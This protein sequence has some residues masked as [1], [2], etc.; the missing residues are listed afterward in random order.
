M[1]TITTT[2][3]TTT[4]TTTTTTLPHVLFIDDLQSVILFIA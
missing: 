4:T 2:I 1:V 3:I